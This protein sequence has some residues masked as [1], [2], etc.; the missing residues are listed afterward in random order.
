MIINFNIPG[1]I[2]VEFYQL[3]NIYRVCQFSRGCEH[4]FSDD[5]HSKLFDL[6]NLNNV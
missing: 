5:L 4:A 3:E 2:N 6:I 1:K